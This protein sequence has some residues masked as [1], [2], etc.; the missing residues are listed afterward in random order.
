MNKTSADKD[1]L[2]EEAARQGFSVSAKQIDRWRAD[3]VLPPAGK[4][5]GGRARGVQRPAPEGSA[6]E[7]VRLCQFLDDD[8]SLDRAAFRLWIEDYTIPLERV[9]TALAQL[10]PNPKPILG[11]SPDQLRDK[12]EQYADSLGRRKSAQPHVKKMAADGRLATVL[13]GF[14]ALGVGR[15]LSPE[16][17]Q[18]LGSDF[19]ELSGLNRG[20]VDH[21]EGKS[22]WLTSDDTGPQ[23]AVAAS[24]LKALNADLPR[25]ASE[26][27]FLK[28]KDAF[29]STMLF[30]NCAALLQQ[31]HGPN[32][33]GFGAVTDLP[34]GLPLRYADPTAFLL[35]MLGLGKTHRSFSTT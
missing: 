1:R 16:E 10:A 28:A 9:R 22:P 30:R 29:K 15:S 2:I 33:F 6:A 14:F 5:G 17:Q 7:L 3:Q 32:V 19:E 12:I 24:M 23:L 13:E 34:I 4:A 26:E 27:E 20:R 21:W 11:D 8:R 35:G 31:L 25:S 18:K